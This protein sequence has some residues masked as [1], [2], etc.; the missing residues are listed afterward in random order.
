MLVDPTFMISLAQEQQNYQYALFILLG[1]G[2]LM[3]LLAFCGCCGALKESRCMLV[4]FFCCMLIV[5][6]A[7]IAA[8]VWAYQ[9]S[10]KLES[11]VK[12]N[13]KHTITQEYSVDSSRTEV[14][15]FLQRKLHCCGVDGPTDWSSAKYN[16]RDK[17]G[18]LDLAISA[19]KLSYAV[20]PSCKIYEVLLYF[21]YLKFNID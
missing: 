2:V 9:N 15:D 17:G 13:F 20:P 8:G 21:I 7:E 5:L 10:D 19:A 16:N 1:I 14:V 6:T 11:F 12:N 3:V 18:Y 4:S